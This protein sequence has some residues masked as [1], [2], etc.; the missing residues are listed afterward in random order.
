[1]IKEGMQGKVPGTQLALVII[2]L[3]N[4]SRA[5]SFLAS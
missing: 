3:N 2:I 1:M 4:F 5:Y